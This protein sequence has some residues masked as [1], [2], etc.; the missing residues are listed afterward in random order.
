MFEK[1]SLKNFS[2]RKSQTKMLEKKCLDFFSN[3]K[4]QTGIKAKK[5]KKEIV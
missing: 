3:R 4:V 2:N 1:N 5:P